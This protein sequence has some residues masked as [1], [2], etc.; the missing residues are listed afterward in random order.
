MLSRTCHCAT[1]LPKRWPTA[2]RNSQHEQG[3][4]IYGEEHASVHAFSEPYPAL[5][6]LTQPR[7][8]VQDVNAVACDRQGVTF[9]LLEIREFVIEDHRDLEHGPN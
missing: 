7:Q 3:C 8:G 9:E 2:G 5:R 4:K 6:E 1:L